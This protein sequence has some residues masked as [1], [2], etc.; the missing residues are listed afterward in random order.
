MAEHGFE[1]LGH[2]KFP[3][4]VSTTA[5]RRFMIFQERYNKRPKPDLNETRQLPAVFDL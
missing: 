5:H 3:P 2:S 4:R 1:A